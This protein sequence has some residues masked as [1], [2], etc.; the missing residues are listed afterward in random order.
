[1]SHFGLALL[2]IVCGLLVL[3]V[4]SNYLSRGQKIT[5][6]EDCLAQAWPVEGS[7]LRRWAARRHNARLVLA[8]ARSMQSVSWCLAWDRDMK[9]TLADM[10]R[11]AR[12]VDKPLFTSVFDG[13]EASYE[14]M[15]LNVTHVCMRLKP[16]LVQ[17]VEQVL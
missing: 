11:C 12:Q 6:M 1:M 2:L 9:A 14:R 5:S 4:A 8:V 13:V 15:V 7:P 10:E 16:E 17:R 3:S